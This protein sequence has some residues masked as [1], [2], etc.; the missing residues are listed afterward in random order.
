MADKKPEAKAGVQMSKDQMQG[1]HLGA[2]ETLIKER[3]EL[4]RILGIVEQLVAMHLK[5]LQESGFDL[6]KLGFKAPAAGAAK[7]APKGKKIEEL[8]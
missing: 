6:Q 4:A 3:N 7:Q 2:L 5:S 8:L 1:Y